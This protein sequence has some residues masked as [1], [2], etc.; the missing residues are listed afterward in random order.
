MSHE[1]AISMRS[2]HFLD[3]N[4]MPNINAEIHFHNLS[5]LLHLPSCFDEDCMVKS[6]KIMNWDVEV[7]R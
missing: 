5:Y 2:S 7:E 4:L 6:R 1:K 3:R